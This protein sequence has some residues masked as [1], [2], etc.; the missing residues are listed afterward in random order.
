MSNEIWVTDKDGWHIAMAKR[1]SLEVEYESGL[2]QAFDLVMDGASMQS[3]ES[4]LWVCARFRDSDRP[5]NHKKGLPVLHDLKL[6]ERYAGAVLT[7]AKRFEVRNDDR[8]YQAGDLVRFHVVDDEGGAVDSPLA[9][10]LGRKTYRIGYVLP[11]HNSYGLLAQGAC[12]FSI[13]EVTDRAS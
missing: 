5:R 6:N 1:G 4:G 11:S 13:E 3:D 10:E 9:E 8:C 12:A 7:E 2:T